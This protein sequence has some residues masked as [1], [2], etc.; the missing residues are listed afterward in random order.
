M[1]A[2]AMQRPAKPSL[3]P[4]NAAGLCLALA[5]LIG[6][7]SLIV[8]VPGVIA[9]GH[10]SG[11][12]WHTEMGSDQSASIWTLMPLL[13]TGLSCAAAFIGLRSLASGRND[14]ADEAE[15]AA[16]Q[17]AAFTP[18]F[19]D[20]RMLMDDE[21]RRWSELHEA[22]ATASREAM[23]IGARLAG[24][25]LDAEKRLSSSVD[26]A[27]QRLNGAALVLEGILGAAD[28]LE[29]TA[30]DLAM[31][32]LERSAGP[33]EDGQARIALHIVTEVA[34]GAARALELATAGLTAQIGAM[35]GA[36]GQMQRDAAALDQACREIATVGAS[37]VARAN[38][39]VSVVESGLSDVPD[40]LLAVKEQSECAVQALETGTVA[41]LESAS[42]IVA[43]KND[44]AT[45]SA[46]LQV[47]TGSLVR[48]GGEHAER[49]SAAS[50]AL[51][52][53]AEALPTL[54]DRLGDD[55]RALERTAIDIASAAHA[56]AAASEAATAGAA[57]I[58]AAARLIQQE[59]EYARLSADA[60]VASGETTR[61]M[62]EHAT[63][64][65]RAEIPALAQAAGTAVESLG[66]RL[67]QVEIATDRAI[68]R[69]A[70]SVSGVVGALDEVDRR[71]EQMSALG[72][73][74]VAST[75][76]L[77]LIIEAAIAH[78]SETR[79][80]LADT[81]RHLT[82]AMAMA[83]QEAGERS[84]QQF[85]D[86]TAAAISDLRDHLGFIE[87][88]L[89]E[90]GAALRGDAEILSARAEAIDRGLSVA[91]VNTATADDDQEIAIKAERLVESMRLGL[92]ELQQ[93]TAVLSACIATF[94]D[95]SERF[96]FERQQPA[97]MGLIEDLLH[98]VVA[99]CG[100]IETNLASSV[101]SS[102][103]IDRSMHMTENAFLDWQQTVPAQVAEM[104]RLQNQMT[105]TASELSQGLGRAI[106]CFA[107]ADRS[108][109]RLFETIDKVQQA[110]A[111]VAKAA[112]SHLVTST[113]ADEP[114]ELKSPLVR[115]AG[116]EADVS[117]LLHA[118][119]ALAQ[120]ALSG[121]AADTPNWISG[122]AP[123]ILLTVDTVI[124]LL[125]S[126]ATSVALASDATVPEPVSSRIA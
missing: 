36:S 9:G 5:V 49:V 75:S 112:Q 72:D 42:A 90:A 38:D 58:E 24:F 110:A 1:G 88:T 13:S 68:Q 64:G 80:A 109:A 26:R 76:D 60:C 111:K 44:A 22:D 67:Q 18:V 52:A 57:Q 126:V 102:T 50:A 20:M 41:L 46:A 119:E 11:W 86:S 15:R 101:K 93:E 100:R 61:R 122:R 95:R 55:T 117:A 39:A 74:L 14:P 30:S 98:E 27:G 17:R 97:P 16:A 114:G 34:D 124:H 45:A 63:E 33:E 81:A 92:K 56:S 94:T 37:I 2:Q 116:V 66:S 115:L 82:D 120:A 123:D 51:T 79:H 89:A 103:A 19:D 8:V 3:R 21:R 29:R 40:L 7:V 78:G 99:T 54:I 105:A 70:A 35:E 28:R 96:M 87:G 118:S 47:Q 106:Q 73:G 6:I 10:A 4:N 32:A 43:A 62:I 69:S 91:H 83:L 77:R 108:E 107:A 65:L 85:M 59:T 71:L 31:R 104:V 25:A 121:R 48:A 125:R 84:A 12:T 23:V 53:Q 113:Q